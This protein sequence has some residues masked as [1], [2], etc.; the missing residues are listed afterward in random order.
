MA[1]LISVSDLRTRFDIDKSIIDARLELHVGSA[2]RRLQKWVGTGTYGNAQHGV[3][4]EAA[5]DLANAEAHLAM[6]F[7][8]VG[9]NSPIAQK[10][11]VTEAR[12]GEGKELR[13]YLSPGDTQKLAMQY[14]EQAREIAEPYIGDDGSDTGGFEVVERDCVV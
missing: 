7:A 11:V 14:L 5:E 1:T 10:G 4:A 6:H 8:I 9:L 12:S 2:S 13:R 3:T